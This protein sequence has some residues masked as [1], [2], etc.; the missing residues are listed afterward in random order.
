L[1]VTIIAIFFWFVLSG[2]LLLKEK[3]REF[4]LEQLKIVNEKK[5]MGEYD[6]TEDIEDNEDLTRLPVSVTR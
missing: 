1:I 4:N 3:W 5:V 2:P 6:E